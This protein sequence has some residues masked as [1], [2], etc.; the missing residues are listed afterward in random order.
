MFVDHKG[1]LD[2]D[3]LMKLYDSVKEC[4]SKIDKIELDVEERR[5]LNFEIFKSFKSKI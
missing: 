5:R 1:A 3:T 4:E 2:F